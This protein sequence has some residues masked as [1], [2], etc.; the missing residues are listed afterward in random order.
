MN[1]NQKDIDENLLLQYLLGN[2]DEE[3]RFKVGE[4]LSAGSRNRMHLDRLESLWLETGKLS[5][6]PVSVDVE[7]AWLR[8]TERLALQEP[9]KPGPA[10]KSSRMISARYLL[11]AAAM[12]ILLVGI[13]SLYRYIISPVQQTEI[14]SGSEIFHNTLPDGSMVILNTHSKLIFPEEFKKGKRL[15]TFAGEA[16]FEVKHDKSKP[17]IVNTGIAAVRVLGTSFR[18]KTQPKS[19]TNIAGEVE[20]SV[21]EGRVMLFVVDERSGDTAS[22]ILAAGESGIWKSGM[23]TPIRNGST[24]PDVHYWANHLLEFR[25]NALSE[26][27][28][29]LEKHY[30]V[31]ITVGDPKVMDCRLTASF[32]NEPADRILAVIAGSFGLG[33]EVRGQNYHFT[34]H[35]CSRKND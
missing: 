6:V 1:Q 28:Q 16:Y 20:V 29:L 12:V 4:W 31:K 18:V 9:A 5:P 3:L 32:M 22:V 27:F 10:E 11:G 17:F 23:V 26:V 25:G 8:M 35:G 19:G 15:V 34:G 7:A 24:A 2:A 30:S 21:T 13:Y 33:L 14:S